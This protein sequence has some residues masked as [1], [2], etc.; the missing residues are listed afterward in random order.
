MLLLASVWICVTKTKHAHIHNNERESEKERQRAANAGKESQP[1]HT[2]TQ[3]GVNLFRRRIALVST[4]TLVSHPNL[5]H[6]MYDALFV[7]SFLLLFVRCGEIQWICCKFGWNY[8]THTYT[9]W[10]IAERV[11]VGVGHSAKRFNEC[12]RCENT[13]AP[14]PGMK[15]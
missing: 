8:A 5:P 3:T 4:H 14:V 15:E 10:V 9:C 12:E 7:C 6:P 1:P 13:F 2:Y 11:G